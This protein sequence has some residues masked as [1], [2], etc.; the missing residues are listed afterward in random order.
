VDEKI[1]LSA[2]KVFGMISPEALD[3]RTDLSMREY[4]DLLVQYRVDR[5]A[6]FKFLMEKKEYSLIRN[7]ALKVD[8]SRF[9]LKEKIDDQM[10]VLSA[11]AHLPQYHPFI[12]S[13]EKAKSKKL[14]AHV[15]MLI[16]RYTIKAPEGTPF[17]VV[18]YGVYR[19]GRATDPQGTSTRK[20]A[21]EPECISRTTRFKGEPGMFFG[22]RFTAVCPEEAPRVSV[23]KVTVTHPYRNEAGMVQEAR[24]S[25]DQNG[26]SSSNIFMGWYFEPAEELL[27]GNYHMAAH[28][29]DGHLLA[30]MMFEVE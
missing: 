26:Y 16:E 8:L 9:I 19:M 23:H 27:T 24:S 20:T 7:L 30:E 13:L 15:K 22:L 3:L 29:T 2:L 25:W 1:R 6:V 5:Q 10:T 4:C 12:L 17:R 21:N 11:L 18:D 28:D 14:Q